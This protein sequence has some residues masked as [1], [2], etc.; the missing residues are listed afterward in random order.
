MDENYSVNDSEHS[1][2]PILCMCFPALLMR[3]RHSFTLLRLPWALSIFHPLK[4][5]QSNGVASYVASPSNVCYQ[6]ACIPRAA[7]SPGNCGL[8]IE[9]L[10]DDVELLGLVR[11]RPL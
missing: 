9:W 11:L 10:G 1:I 8:V 4:H 7:Y 5:I 2:C 6:V 3:G